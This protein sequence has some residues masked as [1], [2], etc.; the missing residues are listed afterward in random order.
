MEDVIG[1]FPL[2]LGQESL[3]LSDKFVGVLRPRQHRKECGEYHLAGEI[4]WNGHEFVLNLSQS[5][6]FGILKR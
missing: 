6:I 3:A 1:C 2:M 5:T 4:S